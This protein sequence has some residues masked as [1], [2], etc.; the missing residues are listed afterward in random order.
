MNHLAE[1][2]LKE[3]ILGGHTTV[4]HY[5]NTQPTAEPQNICTDRRQHEGGCAAGRGRGGVPG[6]RPSVG[7]HFTWC[8]DA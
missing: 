8:S 6:V 7:V 4:Y 1:Q 5:T 2:K 3:F